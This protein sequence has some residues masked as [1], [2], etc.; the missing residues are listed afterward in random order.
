MKILVIGKF[1]T[2]GFALHITETLLDMKHE[3]LH[4]EIGAKSFKRK[5]K[6]WHRIDQ[7]KRVI[8]QATDSIPKIRIKRILPLFKLVKSHQ[9]DV[10][11][12]CHDFLLPGEVIKL[13]EYAPKSKI[14]MWF[15]DALVNFGKGYFMNAPYD[16]LF[17]KDPFIIHTLFNV[18]SSPVYYMPECFN[19]QRHF[20]AEG[21]K[22]EDKYHCDITTAGNSHSWRI[23]YYQHLSEYDVKLWGAPAPL[24]MPKDLVRNLHQNKVVH[25][26]IK[27]KAFLGAKIV[28]NNLHYGEI[29]G[30]NARTFE[31]AGIGS[32][33]MVD[34]RPGLEQLFIDG[35]E[36]I[37]YRS[38]ED[39]HTKIKYW[40]A[41]P[42]KRNQIAEAGKKRALKEHTYQHR[43]ELLLDTLAGNAKGYILPKI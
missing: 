26:Q 22:I 35:E 42:E 13:K 32:F 17:F 14:A 3:V 37:S 4:Y 12:V 6:L 5:S 38:L 2:E 10:I 33:Q 30:L 7:M 27:A 41:N 25:N 29:W 16:G 15:P 20:L 40:L 23:A 43:L 24:W 9:P 36:I 18:L 28:L 31:A 21:V 19:P 1:Y 8:Y 39:M 34:W 11:L